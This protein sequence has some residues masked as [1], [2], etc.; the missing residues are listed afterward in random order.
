MKKIIY[1]LLLIPLIS[2]TAQKR[3]GERA[4]DPEP[5]KFPPNSWGVDIIFSESGFGL[6][7]FYWRQLH[8]DLHAFVDFSIG[9][10][11]D[12][13]EIEYIDYY[14]NLIT[15]GKVNRV[16]ILPLNFGFHYRLFKKDLTDNLRP[17]FAVGLGPH[18]IVSTPYDQEFF[19]SFGDAKLNIAA[20][21][22][23]GVGAIFGTNKKNLFGMIITYSYTHLF[24]AG[25]ENL[26]NRFRTNIGS[27][28]IT[29]TMGLMYK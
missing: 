10:S 28:S 11:K 7:T 19:T 26:E 9:E 13:R 20:G 12:E 6:G 1:I 3:I 2:L 4:P 15:I 18:F 24:G 14:G 17:Y 25:I 22:Y 16:F 21:G 29:L 23:F 27:I 8:E 5:M